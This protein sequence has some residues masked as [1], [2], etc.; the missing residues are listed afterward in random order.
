MKKLLTILAVLEA[1]GLA[2]QVASATRTCDSVI[3]P[4]EGLHVLGQ[5]FKQ[6]HLLVGRGQDNRQQRNPHEQ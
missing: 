1:I 3:A 6:G 5:Y 4:G 2:A